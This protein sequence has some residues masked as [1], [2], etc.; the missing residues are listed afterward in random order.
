[1]GFGDWASGDVGVGVWDGGRGWA[2]WAIVA[3][4]K[5][6]GPKSKNCLLFLPAAK[7]AGLWMI[8]GFFFFWQDLSKRA[9]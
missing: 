2:R 6:Q 7:P 4:A 3:K 9:M 8:F 5:A 1:M